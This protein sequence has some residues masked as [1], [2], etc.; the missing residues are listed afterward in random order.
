VVLTPVLVVW[1]G[2]NGLI[3]LI[4]PRIPSQLNKVLIITTHSETVD[5]PD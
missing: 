4:G 3:V 5:M 1:I 2:K